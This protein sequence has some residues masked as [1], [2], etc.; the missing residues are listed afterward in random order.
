MDTQTELQRQPQDTGLPGILG[1][2]DKA[3]GSRGVWKKVWGDLN[4]L[5]RGEDLGDHRGHADKD[6]Y[7]H[8][9]DEET[10]TRGHT[11]GGW[12]TRAHTQTTTLQSSCPPHVALGF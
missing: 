7:P 3:V 5:S 12:G 2:L 4:Q 1:R 10:V 6:R 11:A 9:A 8:F